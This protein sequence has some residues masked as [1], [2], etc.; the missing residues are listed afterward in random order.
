M[1][2]LPACCPE[3]CEIVSD[4]NLKPAADHGLGPVERARSVKREP[5]LITSTTQRLWWGGVRCYLGAYHRLK[6]EN[7]H[8]VPLTPPFVLVANHASHLDALV[9]GVLLKHAIRPHVFPIAAAD[10]FFDTP[11]HSVFSMVTLN[12]LPMHRAN[13]GR[14]ALD[15]LRHRMVSE[16]CSYILFPEGKR[17]RDGNLNPFRPGIGMILAETDVP[18]V[19]CWLGGCFEAWKPTTFIPRPRQ[20]VARVGEP[21]RFSG[22]KNDREGWEGI[23]AELDRRVRALGGLPPVDPAGPEPTIPP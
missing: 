14:H 4:W 6:I 19:P 3:G 5:G 23:A 2:A 16:P 13:R 15:D 20:I 17:S 7:R 11:A 12:A 22:M 8:H 9:L 1:I 10:V 18:V 21:V